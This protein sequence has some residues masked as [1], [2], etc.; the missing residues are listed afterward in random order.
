MGCESQMDAERS[1]RKR[2]SGSPDAFRALALLGLLCA[3]AA[4]LREAGAGESDPRLWTS[5][6]GRRLEARLLGLE[7]GDPVVLDA[8]GSRRRLPLERL[9]EGDREWLSEWR[10]T[11]S[12]EEAQAPL[13]RPER[14]RHPPVKLAKDA[15]DD[16][17]LHRYA[18]PVYDIEVDHELPLA[19]VEALATMAEATVRLVDQLPLSLPP[20][21]ERRYLARLFATREGFE[22]GG[23]SPGQAGWFHTGDIG[24]PGALLV[25]VESLGLAGGPGDAGSA[26]PGHVLRH[27]IAH[28]A[29]AAVNPLIPHWLREGLAEVVARTPYRD[30]VFELGERALVDSLRRRQEE[31]RRIGAEPDAFG[32]AGAA[33]TNV[34]LPEL[35]AREGEGWGQLPIPEQHRLYF[36]AQVLTTWFLY[37]EG[38]GEARRLRALFDTVS[39][40][41]VYLM[42]RGVEGSWPDEARS[43]EGRARHAAMPP[44]AEERLRGG[45]TW[46]EIDARLLEGFGTRWGIRLAEE[47]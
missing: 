36:T 46:E 40:A 47:R 6:D 14:V 11:R 12:G 19:T 10:A 31:M 35:V 44:L 26:T 17:R 20:R 5:D 39:E 8:E 41:S 3:L 37:L 29:T 18:G 33:R 1:S 45:E 43:A 38:D 42:T 22:Q 32:R 25:P 24:R 23:G 30:G 2:E 34:P 4:P 13:A 16:G 21:G 15:E 28:Q 27:E 7:R 9:S